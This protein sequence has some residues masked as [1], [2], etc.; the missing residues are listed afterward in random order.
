MTFHPHKQSKYAHVDI[1]HPSFPWKNGR[2]DWPRYIA[3]K[4][5]E[6]YERN[7]RKGKK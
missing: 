4:V 5:E 3:D 2:P 1:H 6:R 7:K